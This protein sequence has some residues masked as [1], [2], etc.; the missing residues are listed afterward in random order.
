M[1]RD[2]TGRDEMGRD[3]MRRDGTGRDGTGWDGMGQDGLLKPVDG[4]ST[5]V[6][7]NTNYD[8]FHWTYKFRTRPASVFCIYTPM[9]QRI[10]KK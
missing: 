1:G 6:N 7:I 9:M 10:Q 4:Q 2:G 5:Q 3:G 8:A